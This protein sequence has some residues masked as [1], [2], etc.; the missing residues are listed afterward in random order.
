MTQRSVL[1]TRR[2]MP[3]LAA[4]SVALIATVAAVILPD[5]SAPEPGAGP[6]TGHA[7]PNTAAGQSRL[8]VREGDLVEVSGTVVAAPGRPVVYR[9]DL[10]SA[11][12]GR[13]P[14][15]EPPPTCSATFAVTLTGVDLD[16]L[17]DP[18][19]RKGV[20]FGRVTLRGVWH[21]RTIEV[22]EQTP[23]AALPPVLPPVH[24]TVPCPAP[25]GGWKTGRWG[26]AL[27]AAQKLIAYVESRPDR[28]VGTAVAT[29]SGLPLTWTEPPA[30]VTEVITV[31]VLQGDLAHAR[32]DLRKLYP[33][34]LCVY[35]GTRLFAPA[36]VQTANT[37]MTNL[38]Q[39]TRNG[40]W[41]FGPGTTTQPGDVE[42]L[43]LD[44]RVYG[45]IEKIGL[46]YFELKPAVR[47]VR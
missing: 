18:G 22:R 7:N 30:I 41:G 4:V 6:P 12:V 34:N 33:G 26:D 11:G 37:S 9:P 35:R 16:R 1:V 43:V 10:P 25:P 21:G 2:W 23:P 44:E 13:D 14:G 40:I 24:G 20:R 45:E 36:E 42:L 32:R 27:I 38:L 5:S 19:T 39:D 3:A 29:L 46:K 31:S 15:D 17:A 8:L 28:F 47:P